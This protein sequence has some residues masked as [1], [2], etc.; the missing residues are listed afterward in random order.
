M[1][2]EKIKIFRALCTFACEDERGKGCAHGLQQIGGDV[3]AE[4]RVSD[5]YA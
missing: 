1:H 5:G 2:I 3:E 4:G